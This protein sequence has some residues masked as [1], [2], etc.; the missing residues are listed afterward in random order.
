MLAGL[1][2]FLAAALAALALASGA[3]AQPFA[4]A[5]AA[6]EINLQPHAAISI[7]G[8]AG[9]DASSGVRSGTGTQEDPFVIANW[10]VSH[11]REVAFLL[12]DTRAFVRI[13]NILILGPEGGSGGLAA[14]QFDCTHS[15]RGIRLENAS[16]VT[17][18]GVTILNEGRA[19][20]IEDSSDVDAR[21][22]FMGA[23]RDAATVEHAAWVKE[24]DHVAIHRMRTERATFPLYLERASHVL[25]ADSSLLGLG[26]DQMFM[27][28]SSNVSLVR[29]RIEGYETMVLDRMNDLTLAQNEF[30]NGAAA[31]F[32]TFWPIER[33]L[34][35]GN[36]FS[37]F[38][39]ESGALDLLGASDLTVSGNAFRRNAHAITIEGSQDLHFLD[40]TLEGETGLLA[41]LRSTGAF[42]VH[43]NA[44]L[45]PPGSGDGVWLRNAANA[46][47]NWWGHPTGPSRDGPGDGTPLRISRVQPA[48]IEPWLAQDPRPTIGCGDRE[49][50]PPAPD[51]EASAIARATVTTTCG[52]R[53]IE[54]VPGRSPS[55][56]ATLC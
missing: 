40:N 16:H 10:T 38:A 15:R 33:A 37:G 11:D 35:C 54:L 52:T 55:G 27:V 49:L 30:R 44:F 34:V 2:K 45:Q 43:G 48:T 18:E 13:E 25:I 14:C 29:D 53:A 5:D 56:A 20:D 4:P 26:E 22:L 3:A 28:D 23:S 12:K 41:W 6:V 42:E 39:G 31:A 50:P 36:L 21:D 24:S 19:L 51:V 17:L 7:V 32:S 46:S 1:S 47:G 9:F 8:D